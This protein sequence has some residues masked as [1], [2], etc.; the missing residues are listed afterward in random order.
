MR[1]SVREQRQVTRLLAAAVSPSGGGTQLGMSVTPRTLHSVADV[2]ATSS[3]MKKNITDEKKPQRHWTAVSSVKTT[4]SDGNGTE[5]NSAIN[6]TP[7][8][9]VLLFVIVF[10]R[11]RQF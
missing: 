10:I 1:D 5:G 7:D 2:V 11:G 9:G 8:D 6:R 3:G 4:G